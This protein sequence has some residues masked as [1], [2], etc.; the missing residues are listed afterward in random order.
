MASKKLEEVRR[1]DTWIFEA[2]IYEN[3][4]TNLADLADCTALVQVRNKDN[5][6]IA[7]ASEIVFNGSVLT[8]TFSAG[9]TSGIEPGTYFTSIRITY[10]DGYSTS[11]E[12][13]TLPVSNSPSYI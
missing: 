2:T 3:G 12:T 4:T 6:L 9:T 11:T 8:I 5:D 10:P 7:S 13:F 1:G